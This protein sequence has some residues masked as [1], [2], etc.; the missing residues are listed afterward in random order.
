MKERLTNLFSHKKRSRLLLCAALAAL[1]L[2]GG[3]TA[4]EGQPALSDQEAMEIFVS[5]MLE[6][7][8]FIRHLLHFQHREQIERIIVDG[9]RSY[10]WKAYQLRSPRHTISHTDLELMLDFGAYG[11]S[12]LMLQVGQQEQVDEKRLADQLCR[13][14]TGR[15]FTALPGKA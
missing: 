5:M 9:V 3:L 4:C 14:L 2:L 12:G 6:N 10:L 7:R 13:L 15:L 11:L 1:L 8:D